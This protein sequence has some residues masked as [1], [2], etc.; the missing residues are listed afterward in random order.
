M[1]IK[2]QIIISYT[3]FN[4][5]CFTLIGTKQFLKSI[6]KPFKVEFK[7]IEESL[8]AAKDEVMEELQ[9]A[10][11]QAA[12]NFHHLLT[13]KIEENRIQHLFVPILWYK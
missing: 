8:I 1:K 2:S 9:L 10:S 13:T 7:E 4:P 6:W 12:Y 11:K 3:V 5:R